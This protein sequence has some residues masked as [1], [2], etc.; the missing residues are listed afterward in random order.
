MEFSLIGVFSIIDFVV[1]SFLKDINLNVS[2]CFRER[3]IRAAYFFFLY[4]L[5]GS[6]VIVF[7]YIFIQIDHWLWSFINVYFF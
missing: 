7:F 1:L 6:G 2:D 3:K 4:T 5:L